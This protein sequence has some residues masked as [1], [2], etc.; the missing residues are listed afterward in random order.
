MQTDIIIGILI[1]LLTRRRLTARTLAE[2][3]GISSRTVYRYID[4]LDY[5]GVPITSEKGALGGIGI[6]D[7]YR[8]EKSFFTT[9]EYEY[10]SGVLNN[11]CE[12]TPDPRA[13]SVRDKIL[14][15]SKLHA[16]D[17]NYL[18]NTQSLIIDGGGW[19]NHARLRGKIQIINKAIAENRLLKLEYYD[20]EMT[21]TVRTV[22]P[23]TLILKEGF[24]LYAYCRLRDDFRHFRIARIKSITAEDETFAR[25]VIGRQAMPGD[26]VPE[27]TVTLKISFKEEARLEVEEWLGFDAVKDD[28]ASAEVN[29]SRAL[30]SKILSLGGYIEVLSPPAVIDAIKKELN[31]ISERYIKQ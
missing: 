7:D 2:R 4:V 25:R 10:L 12:V 13:E 19:A 9:G 15:L 18:I 1:Q 21:A 6:S 5:A 22:E 24:Y 3:Y 14:S 17:R 31:A 8:L 11:L 28:T 16:D 23:H 20:V 26:T 27:R 30:T 29:L